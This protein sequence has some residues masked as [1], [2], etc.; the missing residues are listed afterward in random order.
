MHQKEEKKKHCNKVVYP[1]E[2]YSLMTPPNIVLMMI[3]FLYLAAI[4]SINKMPGGEQKV[5]Q[6]IN[7]K[8]KR[9][10]NSLLEHCKISTRN[11]FGNELFLKTLYE[12]SESWSCFIIIIFVLKEGL[13]VLFVFT[14]RGSKGPKPDDVRHNER[15][16][17]CGTGN[18]S[19]WLC[20]GLIVRSPTFN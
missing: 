3:L 19:T 6:G 7:L 4:I 9:T 2:Y 16:R 8:K 17:G 11:P 13:L 10:I 18:E 14:L 5:I 15:Q 1:W 20:S 12:E